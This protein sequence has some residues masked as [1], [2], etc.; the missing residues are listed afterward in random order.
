MR[1]VAADP[2]SIPSRPS[3]CNPVNGLEELEDA[4]D[5]ASSVGDGGGGIPGVIGGDEPALDS[6]FG[7]HGD[8]SHC[9]PGTGPAKPFQKWIKTLHKRALRRKEIARYDSKISPWLLET[10]DGHTGSRISSHD[11]YSSSDSSFGFV[12]EVKTISVSLAGASMSTRSRKHTARS[13]RGQRTDRSSRASVSVTRCSEDSFCPERQAPID[14][15]VVERSLQRRRILEELVRTEEGYIGDLRFLI[16][17]YVTILAS[18]PVSPAGLRSSVNRNLTD[19]VELHEEIL[20]ELHRALSRSEY[21]PLDLSIQQTRSNSSMYAHR[22][23]R[24][25]D[26]VWEHSN[27]TTCLRDI[28]EAGTEPQAAAEAA[29]VFLKRMNRFFIYEEYGAK[30][31]LLTRDVLAAHRT[32]PGWASYQKGLEILASSLGPADSQDDQARKSLTL[33]DLLVKPIQRV[34]KYPL[35]FSE[36]LKH[37]PVIDCPYSHMEIENTLSRLR[38]VTAEINRATNDSRTKSILEK[39]WILQDRLVFAN[40]QLDAVSKKRIRAFGP[41]RLCGALHVCWQTKEGVKG[42]Y[43]VA[44]LYR[45]C[46]CLATA[47][48]LGQI[49][50]I[51]ACIALAD[52]KL[53]EVDNERGLQCHTAPHSWKI[54]FLC[55]RQLYELILTA[56]SPKEELQWRARLRNSQEAINPKGQTQTRSEN[57]TFLALNI[58]ALG[59]VFRKP[60]TAARDVSIHRATTIGPRSPLCQVIL[61]N[62]SAKKESAASGPGAR[63][64]RSQSLLTTNS[65]IPV[66]APS[67]AERARV[68]ALL[69]DVWTRDVLPF[70]GITARSKSEHLVRASA[71]SMM[72]RLS[73]SLTTSLTGS[74]TG[75]SASS[76]G[77]Q[78]KG[79][80]GGRSDEEASPVS[81]DG[82]IMATKTRGLEETR[83]FPAP[84]AIVSQ[85]EQCVSPSSDTGPERALEKE[86]LAGTE[87]Q[88]GV[89]FASIPDE[90]GKDA[91]PSPPPV[92]RLRQSSENS[93]SRPTRRHSNQEGSGRQTDLEA[94]DKWKSP[95][96]PYKLP[97][98]FTKTGVRQRDVVVQGIRSWFR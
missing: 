2:R 91:T 63:I 14:P 12:T 16:N 15:V 30:Y 77:L 17:V 42:Q 7:T 73:G 72:R 18:L 59:T 5:D 22:R 89:A 87:S 82:C 68:E 74:F 75:R 88:S 52:I 66:L 61:K 36:L 46:V 71:S 60:G 79:E 43:M 25:L 86:G 3:S 50:T 23:W 32:M 92:S 47:G 39:T 8:H 93:C 6:C 1:R 78:Q 38:E 97:G 54:V 85:A 44:L 56:C 13:S 80:V 98:R 65:R 35:L 41:I 55:D 64:N 34:C 26:A 76:T 67:R 95:S 9:Q 48:K 49:Y 29:S 84:S 90:T 69:S 24:S 62:T 10:A 33:G 37:T 94:S 83:V 45:A 51:E 70:P 96:R 57:F 20:G 21:S 11:R 28:P 27:Q 81:Q 31:E 19:I 40:H 58:T 4:T 53:E